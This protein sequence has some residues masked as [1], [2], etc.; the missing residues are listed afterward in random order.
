MHQ[1]SSEKSIFKLKE[2]YFVK[3]EVTLPGSGAKL[4]AQT[5]LWEM[6]T[7]WIKKYLSIKILYQEILQ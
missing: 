3:L 2:V 1:Q 7:V 6:K 5:L 4:K